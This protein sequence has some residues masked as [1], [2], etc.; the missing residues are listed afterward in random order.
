[1]IKQRAGNRIIIEEVYPEI[2]CGRYPA[3]RVAGDYVDVWADILMDGHD[4]LQAVLA[5]RRK[6]ARKW[7]EVPLHHHG[8][9]RWHGR[10][11]LEQNTRYQFAIHAWFDAFA[12]WRH[13]TQKKCDAKQ[14]I[15]VETTEGRQL[16]EAALARAKGSAK[17]QLQALHDKLTAVNPQE[18]AEIL[19]AETTLPIMQAVPDR[20]HQ[21]SYKTLEIIADRKR[22]AFGAWYEIFPRSMASKDGK[23]GTFKDCIA[24]L[25]DI[26]DMGFDVLYLT[27]IHPIGKT[28]RK[29][30]N[31]TLTAAPGDPGSPYAIGSKEGG[32][33][34][35]HPELGSLK[36]FRELVK[37]ARQHGMEIA[38][39]FAIQCSPDHPWIKDQPDWFSFRPDGTIRY[40]ENPPKKYQDIVNVNFNSSDAEGLWNELRDTVLHWV[41]AGIKIFRVD[42][43]H[44]KPFA[45]WE[46]LIASVQEK[47]PDVIFLAEAFTRPKIMYALAKLGFT[48]SYT[49]FTWRTTKAEL[50]EYL[51]ELTRDWP[52]DY[53]RP[54]FFAN[55][56]DILPD[57]LQNAPISSFIVRLC[58][59]A[60]LAGNYGIYSGYELGE[61]EP[62]ASGKEYNH[63]EK[64]ELKHRDL[65]APGNIRD[66]ITRINNIRRENPAFEN[67][68]SL[69]F[70]P[71]DND[72]IV[73]YG[74][75]S[76]DGKN[77]VFMVVNLDPIN[78]Q[79]AHI[80][81]PLSTFN[82]AP[83]A[84]YT[85]TDLQYGHRWQWTGVRQHQRLDPK[86]NPVAIFR[87]ENAA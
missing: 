16:L 32:H 86:V 68:T 25:P 72:Q 23:H 60:T 15:A 74:K 14:D 66:F 1:M 80:D 26:A 46:W 13:D 24:H 54:N 39:D 76:D 43:P 52:K 51:T 6:D 2:D 63:S 50:T 3:K 48:Q 21:S 45:F 49:Y 53:F 47:H 38:L 19:L 78:V 9:D 17:K 18:A 57:H 40:A 59:A 10:F 4:K 65:H 7:N 85:L 69:R 67:F 42:N 30:R 73:F 34:A 5:W 84:P 41:D 75:T 28:H 12:T 44:T 62:D 58:L 81:M 36:D 61:N 77:A 27:P 70:Y 37:A 83:D 20:A 87:L 33:K 55:T 22:A 56:P 8:N 29:G 79:E 11:Q 71:A 82:I 35:I 31:N 64:Y